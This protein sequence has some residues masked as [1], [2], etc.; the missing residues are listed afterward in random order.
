M[1]RDIESISG[2]RHHLVNIDWDDPTDEDL[3]VIILIITALMPKLT[4][5]MLK[6]VGVYMDD[7]EEENDISA[8]LFAEKP[9]PK[10]KKKPANAIS[11]SLQAKDG[12]APHGQKLP[13]AP[14]HGASGKEAS[15][16]YLG[17]QTEDYVSGSLPLDRVNKSMEAMKTLKRK[18][19]SAVES[20]DVR[21]ARNE[22]EGYAGGQVNDS[23]GDVMGQN[24]D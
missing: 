18:G 21:K 4:Y 10:K 13:A 19:S 23:S 11:S 8:S 16:P 2:G 17:A 15:T 6:Y 12:I 9:L 24:N 5:S 14:S 22:A 20:L 3:A 7:D 1:V